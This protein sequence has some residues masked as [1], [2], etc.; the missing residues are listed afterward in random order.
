MLLIPLVVIRLLIFR[1]MSP[2]AYLRAQ[3]FVPLARNKQLYYYLYQL[4]QLLL[5]V[6]PFFYSIKL[7]SSFNQLGFGLFFL[8]I[9]LNIWAVRSFTN[10]DSRGL[11]S[12]GFFRFLRNPIYLSYFI[13]YIAMVLM[14]DSFL[15]LIVLLVFQLTA[16]QII[17]AEEAWCIE[18]F[19]QDYIDY[20]KRVRRYI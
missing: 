4:A 16:H 20:M 7:E 3:Y 6:L 5:L 11:N 17:L 14:M 12:E 18:Y 9:I 2:D 15:Y 13:Y 19:G 8:A 10:A 1:I